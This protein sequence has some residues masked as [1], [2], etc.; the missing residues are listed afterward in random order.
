CCDLFSVGA[1]SFHLMTGISPFQLW[2]EHG[3]SWMAGWEKYLNYPISDELASVIDKLLKKDV[4]ERYKSAAEVITDLNLPQKYPVVLPPFAEAS[5]QFLPPTEILSVN[6]YRKL[7]RLFLAGAAIIMFIAG[8]FWYWKTRETQIRKQDNSTE[9]ILS[10]PDSNQNLFGLIKTFDLVHDSAS[11]LAISPDSKT[12]LTNS[13]FGIKLW[14]L[15]TKQEISVFDAHNAKV[16]VVAI[17]ADGTKF[18]SGSEDK[19]I[20]IWNLATG[21]EIRTLKG[22]TSG[23]HSLAISP[24]GKTL[25]SGGEDSSV[26]LW[27]IITGKEIVSFDSHNQRISS[28]SFNDEGNILYSGS[29]DGTIKIWDTETQQLLGI[30]SRNS[31]EVNS[32]AFIK[33]SGSVGNSSVIGSYN[34]ELRMW[35]PVSGDTIRSFEGHPQAITSIAVNPQTNL[36]ASGSSDKTIKLWNLN[37]GELLT[38]IR[39]HSAKVKSLAFNR[40]GNILVSSAEDRTIKIWQIS[41]F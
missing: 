39:G 5:E 28:L 6:K 27:N 26:K 41:A 4:E 36:L 12:I 22:H 1:T 15:A 11:S 8:E 31:S 25:A 10:Q 3:Y 9:R 14:S 21:Q 38:T 29:F 16:N 7:K 18:I 24:D 17:N 2:T 13:I 33:Q 32:I 34:N 23:I 19:T 37:T 35:N 40:D 20:K 30:L